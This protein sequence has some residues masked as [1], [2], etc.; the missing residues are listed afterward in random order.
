MDIETEINKLNPKK[1]GTFKNI[2]TKHLIQTSDICSKTL[3]KIWNNEIVG[4][5]HFPDKLK[6]ADITPVLKLRQ[7]NYRPVSVLPTVSKIFVRLMH[8]KMTNNIIVITSTLMAYSAYNFATYLGIE[9]K[10]E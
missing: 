3:L 2:P 1:S 9:E 4:D 5:K 8:N 7:K 10:Y 6:L